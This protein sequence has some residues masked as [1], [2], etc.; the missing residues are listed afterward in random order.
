MLEYLTPSTFSL[1]NARLRV[2]LREKGILQ[3][4]PQVFR[5]PGPWISKNWSVS[6]LS[7]HTPTVEKGEGNVFPLPYP[8]SV[9]FR[10]STSKAKRKSPVLLGERVSINTPLFRSAGHWSAAA[11]ESALAPATIPF[12]TAPS[13]EESRL[14]GTTNAHVQGQNCSGLFCC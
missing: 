7:H 13:R 8:L 3:N 4:L 6:P 12:H 9:F 14:S 2:D 10:A 1:S 11:E 5:V